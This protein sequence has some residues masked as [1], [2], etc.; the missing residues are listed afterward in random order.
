MTAKLS[1]EEFKKRKRPE[2]I[3]IK[4]GKHKEIYTHLNGEEDKPLCNTCN[5]KLRRN[6]PGA[7]QVKLLKLSAT[8]IG[9]VEA[10]LGMP[11]EEKQKKTLQ[12]MED[13]LK[14]MVRSWLGDPQADEEADD[15]TPTEE[16]TDA[17]TDHANDEFA[18][19]R[20]AAVSEESDKLFETPNNQPSAENSRRALIAAKV[21]QRKAKSKAPESA[22]EITETT[23]HGYF[24]NLNRKPKGATQEANPWDIYKRTNGAK[25][26][27]CCRERSKQDAE[28]RCCK[29]DRIA[30]EEEQNTSATTNNEAAEPAAM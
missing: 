11:V 19:A 28:A 10:M 24:A 1:F 18:E 3:C 22:E 20:K 13:K 29:L 7:V 9:S 27:F 25:P 15:T 30:E 26:K 17:P 6:S 4:C 16:A 12:D 8:A 23:P 2:E 21:E 5:M 14:L